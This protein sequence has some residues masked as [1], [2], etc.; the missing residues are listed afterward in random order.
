[1]KM[2]D[3]FKRPLH[4]YTVWLA[5]MALLAV[6][7]ALCGAGM[8]WLL[9][10][11]I[12]LLIYVCRPSSWLHKIPVAGSSDWKTVVI[13]LV[14]TLTVAACILPMNQFSL[15]NGEI[16]GHR[17]QYEL[18][19][20]NILAGRLHFDYGDEDQLLE[21]ENPY[22]PA[23][24]DKA[25]VYYH[26]D[27]AYYNG[28]YYMYF[29][30]V[31][32]F[33]AFLPYRLLTGMPLTTYHGTQLFAAV[34][35]IGIFALLLMLAKRFFPKMSFGATLGF[36]SAISIMSI[37]YST[38][39]PALYCTAITAGIALEVW[40]LY[41]FFRAVWV[42]EKENRQIGFAALGALLGALVFGCRP[43]I[44]L[45]NVIVL[46]MLAAFLKQ[47]KFSWKLLGK[48]GLA[49]LPY[50][51]VAVAL[52]AYNYARFEDPFEFGQAYQLTV[53][54]QTQYAVTLNFREMIRILNGLGE[55]FFNFPRM[56]EGFP[57][58]NHGGAF[59]NF[60]ILFFI[61][62]ALRR[63]S[64]KGIRREKLGGTLVGFVVAAAIITVM[65][66]LWTPYLLER[67]RMDM[68]F[69]LGILCFVAIGFWHKTESDSAR[70]SLNTAV[71]VMSVLTVLSSALLCL[72][73]ISVY[74]PEA[75]RQF[76]TFLFG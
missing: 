37:W 32:V 64:R 29:G 47:H 67:Y 33:L 75:V 63:E 22:D 49:A 53:A 3:F 41:C 44:A 57:Y 17:N 40:S 42:E 16:P 25:G 27:H 20:E 30:V 19:A 68:Y 43:T 52:M 23:E 5:A 45:A 73:T 50:A 66:V 15:W 69:L 2:V 1:M 28:R 36:S 76:G 21:L 59:V 13:M 38:A 10:G 18:M 31:P 61:F 70:R 7:L 9:T 54:D 62:G 55:N 39:E 46:P 65:S 60:P 74:Y 34:A 48:L 4:F 6:L 24:R 12:P 8:A 14:V 58:L 72:R 11:L 26:W 56:S 35:I 51:V 71:V